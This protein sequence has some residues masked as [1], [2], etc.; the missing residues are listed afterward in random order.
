VGHHRVARK[1]AQEATNAAESSPAPDRVAV[2]A[3]GPLV[4][5][6]AAQGGADSLLAPPCPDPRC[7]EYRHRHAS[8]PWTCEYNHPRGESEPDAA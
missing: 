2:T 3:G 8:G 5:L 6:I 4:T 1:R 7:C